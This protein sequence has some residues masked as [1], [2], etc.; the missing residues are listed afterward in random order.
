MID[1]LQSTRTETPRSVEDI[2]KMIIGNQALLIARLQSVVDRIPAMQ[3]ELT[4]LKE[5]VEALRRP[6][7][8]QT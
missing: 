1:T 7:A 6:E 5:T 8:P 2:L 3:A 4:E